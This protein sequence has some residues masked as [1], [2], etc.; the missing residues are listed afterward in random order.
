MIERKIIIGLITSNEYIKQIYSVF[1]PML[2]QSNTARILARWALEY[3]ETYQKAINKEIETIY[4]KKVREGMDEE[5]AEEI[6]QDILPDLSKEF[7]EQKFDT[8]FMINETFNYLKA[9]QLQQL[10]DQINNVL[11]GSGST[12]KKLDEAEELQREFKPI[13]FFKDESVDLSK[14]SALKRIRE[15]FKAATEPII[16]WPKQLGKFWNSSFVRGAFLSLLATEKR[17][18]TFWLLEIAMTAIKQGLKVAFFQAGDMNEAEQLKRIGVYLTKRNNLEEYCGEHYQSVRDC[19]KNQD[20]TCSKDERQCDFSPFDDSQ[21]DEIDALKIDD[22]IDAYE[23]SPT[24][25]PCHNCRQYQ[26]DK[27]GAPWVKKIKKVSPITSIDVEKI[28]QKQFIDK[29]KQFKLSTHA[30]GTLSVDIA[31]GIL[32]NWEAS[33]GFVP[34][35]I[36]FDYVDIMITSLRMEFRHQE[37]QKWKELRRLSQ[38]PRAEKLPLVISP[39]QAD[40]A[41]YKLHRLKLDNFSEDKRKYGHVTAMWGLNQDPNGREKGI[42]LM[43]INEMIKREGFFDNNNEVTVLQDLWQGRPFTGSYF[44]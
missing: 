13:S 28:V 22:L 39:T 38:T 18:K 20:D 25:S 21:I 31:E 4:H 10:S 41:A 1:N 23:M 32:D 44:N 42:G 11:E 33:E 30:N 9:Q 24:Y 29:N 34:D 19:I 43:R 5:L 8:E 14:K 17:G 12:E 27:L 2:L 3:Y 40:A 6:E 16:K 15:A 35:I 7:V 36:I 26:T 37:N